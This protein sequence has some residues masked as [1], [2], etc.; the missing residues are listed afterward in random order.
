MTIIVRC[1]RGARRVENGE[2]H[3]ALKNETNNRRRGYN[4][5]YQ[6][7]CREEL[8]ASKVEIVTV[9]RMNIIMVHILG[10]GGLRTTWYVLL[11]RAALIL[12][13]Q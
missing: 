5:S 4:K 12:S 13:S 2:K 8:V 6:F 1:W 9:A 11:P 7:L 3:D 10:T